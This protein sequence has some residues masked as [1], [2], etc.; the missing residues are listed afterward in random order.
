MKNNHPYLIREQVIKAI[1]QFFDERSF[2]EITV[3]VLNRALPLEPNL[4][5]FQTNWYHH[6]QQEKL[7]LP[8]SPESALKKMLAQGLDKV[9][10]IAP[11]FRNLEPADVEH[12]P[13]FLM[14]E[15]YRSDAHYT[16]IM[17]DVEKLV[18]FVS[19]KINRYLQRD[20]SVS[21]ILYRGKLL[22]L[23]SPWKVVSLEELFEEVTNF[24]LR[25]CLQLKKMK[26][27]AN[28]L[29]YQV[30]DSNWEQLFNQ[31][32]MDKIEPLLGDQ[33]LFLIDFPAQISS[34][35]KTQTAKPYLADRFEVY[36]AG[37]ELGN[38]NNEQLDSQ[39]VKEKMIKEKHHR[40]ANRLP[41][42]LIE[43]EFLLA[44]DKMRQT[45][46]SYAGIGLGVDRL[47]MILAGEESL[48]KIIYFGL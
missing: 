9:Y 44:L 22:D 8:T 17:R 24:S 47:A 21:K 12:H 1:R 29:N 25:E 26:E 27:L 23:S 33:P 45:N 15:W 31:V 35:C 16:D 20:S 5:S 13:E 7:F 19:K 18:Q 37:L 4:Y 40:E 11:S 28:K 34:L 38:G 3:P 10:A 48:E 36:L 46:T 32:V 42:H 39:L 2:Y 41:T 43:E 30:N 6:D 14:L